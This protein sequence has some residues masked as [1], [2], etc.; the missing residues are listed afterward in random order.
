M[1]TGDVNAQRTNRPFVVGLTGGI[2]SGKTAVSQRLGQLGAVIID[3]D[4][5]ARQVVE[6]QQPAFA[7]IVAHF[8]DSVVAADGTL[9]RAAL[10]K[11]V[12]ECPADRRLL[13]S[14]T[15]PRIRAEAWRQV[16][17]STGPYV[18]LVVPLLVESDIHTQVDRVLVV[19]C[20]P[21]VQLARL[22]DRDSESERA[23]R[24][25]IAAQSDRQFRLQ[26]ADDVIENNGSFED[27]R[28]VVDALHQRY[29]KRA[30]SFK[31]LSQNGDPADAE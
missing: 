1:Q 15:H 9:D 14:Y 19:D 31:R 16:A 29:L 7:D 4:L 11:R 27:L 2:A 3:T 24:A 10:R 6:P 18:V 21:S 28:Q 13:E 23:A 30:E 5:I 26:K 20:E 25:I 8:G 22:I 12:F 17:A